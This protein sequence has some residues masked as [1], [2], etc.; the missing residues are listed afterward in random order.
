M[1]QGGV[2]RIHGEVSQDSRR[3][4]LDGQHRAVSPHHLH[5]SIDPIEFA[6][7]SAALSLRAAVSQNA[8]GHVQV[9]P[10]AV[11]LPDQ[12][13]QRLQASLPPET[14]D[15]RPVSLDVVSA[16]G[17]E[18]SP[19]GQ[20]G[21]PGTAA[22]GLGARAVGLGGFGFGEMSEAPGERELRLNG[23]ALASRCR[24]HFDRAGFQRGRDDEAA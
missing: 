10:A 12:A 5:D 3:S 8:Q 23:S 15:G 16:Y 20:G 18:G 6:N 24:R 22:V 2:L 9:L 7:L 11:R 19:L 17:H 21:A 13:Q 4:V 1:D 14:G